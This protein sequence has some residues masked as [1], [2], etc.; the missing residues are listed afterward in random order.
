MLKRLRGKLVLGA[1]FFV[2][3]Y[4]SAAEVEN[5]YERL[6]QPEVLKQAELEILWE[7][8]LPIR[9]QENLEHLF[10]LGNRIYGL[11]NRNFIFSLSREKGNMIFIRSI[12]GVGLPVVGLGLYQDKLFSVAGSELIEINADSGMDLGS[13]RLEFSASCPAARNE[14]YFYVAGTDRRMRAFR[15][16]DKV[17][18]FEV[19]AEDDSR[20]VSVLA[21][22]EFVIFA[23]DTGCCVSMAPDKPAKLWQFNAAE[24]IARP[25]AKDEQSL[26]AASRD[27]NIYRLNIQTGQLVWKYQTGAMLEKGPCVTES[28]VYQHAQNEGLSAIDKESG[29]LLWQLSNGVDLLA[30]AEGKSYVIT[31]SEMLVVMDNEK[32]KQVNS[33]ELAG[34]SIYA[35]NTAD[36]KIYIADKKGRI[37]CLRPIEY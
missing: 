24:N 7:T 35:A 31:N 1:V 6:V 9:S 3:C 32:A 10:I 34:V 21:D 15:S 8:K 28:V 22:E 29:K 36:S 11:T 33:V 12:A 23:T 4:V 27:T 30:E 26:F 13:K 14:S 17:R 5:G 16:D 37:A 20:I 2:F 25:I 19:A 18:V